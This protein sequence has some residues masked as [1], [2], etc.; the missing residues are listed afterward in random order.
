VPC[1]VLPCSSEVFCLFFCAVTASLVV[2]AS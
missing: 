2:A 1:S